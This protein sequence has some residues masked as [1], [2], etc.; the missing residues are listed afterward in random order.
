MS[1]SRGGWRW[2]LWVL[3]IAVLLVVAWLFTPLPMF[4]GMSLSMNHV[5]RIEARMQQADVYLPVATNLALYCQSSESLRLTNMVGALRL[6]QPLPSLGSPWASFATNYAH[7]EF[8][9]GFYHYGYQV[10]L[11]EKASS[12]RSNVWQLYLCR[13]GQ[14]QKLLH[15][16]VL[17]PSA[18]VAVSA[19]ASNS[20]AECDRRIAKSPGDFDLHKAKIAILLEYCPNEIRAA[21]MDAVD[22]LPEHWWPRLTLALVDTGRGN[23][24]SASRELKRFVEAKPS[25]SRYIYLAYYYQIT[26]KPSEAA[27]AIEKAITFPIVDL[28]DDQN[29][30][31][32]RGYSA[33]LYA[34]R[35]HE[36][37]TV[38]KLCNALLPIKQNGDY[39]KAALRDLRSAAESAVAGSD[40][41]FSP[42]DAILGF[43][44]YEKIDINALRGK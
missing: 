39:A 4:V 27:K 36:Y 20:I 38:V 28:E 9:G 5:R 2:E 41:P 31:E 8:G 11:D 7:V 26:G 30:A 40:A 1:E 25:Y 42:S 35:N 44:P 24:E 14:D 19:L 21:C 12:L 10:Q 3:G 6:P 37:T 43:D 17:P 23:A 18:R 32:C 15:R 16:F 22:K 29:N 34:Y 13:E 33:G